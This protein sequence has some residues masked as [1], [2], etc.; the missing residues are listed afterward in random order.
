MIRSA[1][2]NA[3]FYGFGSNKRIVL[4]DTLLQKGM[5]PSEQEKDV[6]DNEEEKTDEGMKENEVEDKGCTIDEILA[7]LSHELGHWY[8]SHTLKN[9]ILMEVRP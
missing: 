4:F 8:Y 1:H 7:I 3:Y 5:I 2:S 9:I 6:V